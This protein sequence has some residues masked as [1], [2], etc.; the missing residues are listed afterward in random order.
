M[1]QFIASNKL[2]GKNRTNCFQFFCVY[3]QIQPVLE[4]VRRPS[5]NIYSQSGNRL[6]PIVAANKPL[7]DS[8]CM[9][10]APLPLENC[11]SAKCDWHRSVLK[12]IVA[13]VVLIVFAL[14]TFGLCISALALCMGRYDNLGKQYWLNNGKHMAWTSGIFKQC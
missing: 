13:H 12:L 10:T 11:N 1:V 9:Y 7:T 2:V 4:R 3:N 6:D 8:I 14:F 5:Y